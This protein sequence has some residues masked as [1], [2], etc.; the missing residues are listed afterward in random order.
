MI[1]IY[2]MWFSLSLYLCN[3]K[4]YLFIESSETVPEFPLM[5]TFKP[6]YLFDFKVKNLFHITSHLN[7]NG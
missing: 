4:S 5:L 7:E 2:K 6:N 3:H 1:F